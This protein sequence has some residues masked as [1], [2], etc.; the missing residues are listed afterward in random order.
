[1]VEAGNVSGLTISRSLENVL[2]YSVSCML[3]K[4][5][6]NARWHLLHHQ[7]AYRGNGM[8]PTVVASVEGFHI[9]HVLSATLA[10]ICLVTLTFDL[11]TLKLG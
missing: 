1:M 4:K 3:H 8:S 10:L 6:E 2:V 5:E 11:F 9:N 7:Q